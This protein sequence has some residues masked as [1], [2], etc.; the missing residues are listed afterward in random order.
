M[1]QRLFAL[2]CALTSCVGIVLVFSLC[3][4]GIAKVL[5]TAFKYKRFYPII[6]F[7]RFAIAIGKSTATIV[8]GN[9]ALVQRTRKQAKLLP[10]FV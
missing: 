2:T 1:H 5:C 9:K 8:F 7:K 3:E 4:V 10:S 6:L